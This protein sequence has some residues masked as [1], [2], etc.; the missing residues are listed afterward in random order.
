MIAPPKTT[1]SPP[2]VKRLSVRN[3]INGT[4][5]AFDDGRTPLEGLKSSGNVY[6]QQDGTIKADDKIWEKICER[7]NFQYTPT[8][9]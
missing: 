2:P 4:V 7:I 9:R 6:L 8:L 1:V 3:W 5:T